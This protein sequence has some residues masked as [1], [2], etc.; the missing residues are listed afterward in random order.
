MWI[1]VI[2]LLGYFGLLMLISHFTSKSDAGNAVF[3]T[4][5]RQSPWFLVAFGMIGASLSGVT[6]I[7]VPG[8]VENRAFSY[9]QMVMGYLA[10]YAVIAFV[11][12]PLYYRLNLI[13]IY[14]YLQQR[15]G[16]KTYRTGAVFFLVSRMLG[17]AFRLYIVALVLQ[18]L[19]FDPLD[20]PFYIAVFSTVFLIWLYTFRGGMKTII[21]TDTLQTFFMLLALGFSFYYLHQYLSPNKTV[22]EYVFAHEWSK[23]FFFENFGTESRHFV[24]QFVGG[25]FITITMTGLDQDMMQK[26]LTCKSLGEAQKNMFWFSVFLVP[27]NLLFL[28]LGVY[29]YDFAQLTN[30]SASGDTLFPTVAFSEAVPVW[31]GVVF[32]LGLVAAAYSS[33][34]SALTAMTTSFCVDILGMNDEHNKQNIRTRKLIHAAVSVL[35]IIIVIL[36]A[37]LV[38]DNVIKEI[39]TVATFTYGPLLGLFAFGLFS[40]KNSPDYF[41]PYFAILAPLLS[42]LLYANGE[43]WFGYVFSFELLLINGSLMF[44]SLWLSSILKPQK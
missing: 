21:Y 25:M 40:K 22:V 37:Y 3:F 8:W 16:P 12:L 29:L 24:K 4:A 34:D 44:I 35:L 6:F 39:F 20:L 38:S 2:V 32:L 27:I 31:V 43:K 41:I 5:N 19:V 15:F 18:L 1:A 10:G 7:S 30:I 9:M 14:S 28:A 33:A 17:S 13:S 26:N 42:Y 11:L 36:F 23:V